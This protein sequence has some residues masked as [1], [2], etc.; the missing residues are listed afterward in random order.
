M[1]TPCPMGIY[2]LLIY[3]YIYISAF[4]TSHV[5]ILM[6]QLL[7]FLLHVSYLGTAGNTTRATS[8]LFCIPCPPKTFASS[9]GSDACNS[10]PFGSVTSKEIGSEGCKLCESGSQV[11]TASGNR[12]VSS[13]KG[14]FSIS[15]FDLSLGAFSFPSSSAAING[16]GS[17][18]LKCERE[19]NFPNLLVEVTN[20]TVTAAG[21]C[22]WNGISNLSS[23]IRF[24]SF[25]PN[26]ELLHSCGTLSSLVRLSFFT[27]PSFK[28]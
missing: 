17:I 6:F 15:S 1:C 16:A 23:A 11:D 5:S 25:P 27:S 12:C 24:S 28:C 9:E 19:S 26:R 3:I 21:A 18:Q 8:P 22:E 10:C 7:Y 14:A 20:Y 4:N 13:L 2:T